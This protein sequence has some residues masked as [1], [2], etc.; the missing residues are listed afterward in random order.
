MYMAS[1]AISIRKLDL[2]TIGTVLDIYME[3]RRKKN[4]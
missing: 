1:Q 3:L 4:A 2:L